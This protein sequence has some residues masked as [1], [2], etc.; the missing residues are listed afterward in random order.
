MGQNGIP[1]EKYCRTGT[2][3]IYMYMYE[4]N[5]TYCL[6]EMLFSE[7]TLFNKSPES[8]KDYNGYPNFALQK[9]IRN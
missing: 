6:F 5:N 2:S 7:K 4:V 8:S 3:A 1:P 9:H